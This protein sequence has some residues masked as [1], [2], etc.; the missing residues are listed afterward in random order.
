ML[1]GRRR[2]PVSLF[3]L[4]FWF[5]ARVAGSVGARIQPA[6][7]PIRKLLPPISISIATRLINLRPTS[8][9]TRDKEPN[10]GA[11]SR[12]ACRFKLVR[13]QLVFSPDQQLRSLCAVVLVAWQRRQVCVRCPPA[14]LSGRRRAADRDLA[15]AECSQ[16]G[17]ASALAQWNC[18]PISFQFKLHKETRATECLRDL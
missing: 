10:R 12:D 11:E 1:L 7:R 8:R 14:S 18:A 5:S 13:G 9:R 2:S 3:R 17:C 6:S 4:V 16:V 15:P